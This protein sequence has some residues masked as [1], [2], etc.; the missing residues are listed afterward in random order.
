MSTDIVPIQPSSPL[1]IAELQTRSHLI[2]SAMRSVMQEGQ[3]FGKIPG[4]GDKPTLLKSGAEKL[5]QLFQLRS[6]IDSQRD[7]DIIDLPN[8]HR[9]YRISC[10]ITS[11]DGVEWA[12]GLGCCSSLESKYRYRWDNTG[13]PVPGQYW[14]TRD[15]SLLGGPQYIAR[16]VSGSW[17]IFQQ[18]EHPNPA[19]YYNTVL[20]MAKKRALVDGTLT[21]TGASD[22]FTQDIEEMAANKA[23]VQP[24]TVAMDDGLVDDSPGLASIPPPPPAPTHVPTEAQVTERT[25]ISQVSHKEG[26][27][28]GRKWVL[29]TIS[30]SDGQRY[31]T[32]DESLYAMATQAQIN[33]DPVRLEWTKEGRGRK[34][35]NMTEPQQEPVPEPDYDQEAED[36]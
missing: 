7:I 26:E 9:E 36:A 33:R 19:D 11:P 20:K 6:I 18:V 21:A 31:S 23:V 16:K 14:K 12:T 28:R 24:E 2:A 25:F 4:C 5:L 35:Q 30:D 27:T 1:T 3:H 34:L 10:H 32:F 15:V 17:C 13:L 22:M 8:G 29:Y